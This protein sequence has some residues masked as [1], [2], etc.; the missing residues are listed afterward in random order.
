MSEIRG[1]NT[2]PVTPPRHVVVCGAGV[3]GAAV[4]RAGFTWAVV[5][6]EPSAAVTTP[7]PSSQ[8]GAATRWPPATA[9]RSR[10]ASMNVS[11]RR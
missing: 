8:P 9:P 4:K 11:M 7:A 1:R 3:V 6:V 5:S 2:S 10:A